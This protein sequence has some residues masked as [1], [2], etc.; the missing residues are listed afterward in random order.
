MTIRCL[1]RATGHWSALMVL[2]LGGAQAKGNWDEAVSSLS[3]RDYLRAL[4]LFKSWAEEDTLRYRSPELNRNLAKAYWELG[5]TS[6]AVFHLSQS[7][8]YSFSLWTSFRNATD[9]A[10]LE[11]EL[12]V[13]DGLS[14]RVWFLSLFFTESNWTPVLFSIGLW[15]L[16]VIAFFFW[17]SEKRMKKILFRVAVVPILVVSFALL[18]LLS[19]WLRVRCGV[20]SGDTKMVAVYKNAVRAEKHKLIDLPAGTLVLTGGIEE[21]AVELSEPIGGWVA[22]N[23]IRWVF[24]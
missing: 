23:E 19:H 13:R 9:L 2:F 12:G 7:A 15:S 22:A 17:S 18:P 21:G 20:L 4:S 5:Q 8:R 24:R 11:R 1:I 6:D 10:L 3:S 14:S 16:A